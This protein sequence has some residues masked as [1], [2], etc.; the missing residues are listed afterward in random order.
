MQNIPCGLTPAELPA[1]EQS[2]Q[3]NSDFAPAINI[4]SGRQRRISK[5]FFHLPDFRLNSRGRR[6]TESTS[7]ARADTA[8]LVKFRECAERLRQPIIESSRPRKHRGGAA[9]RFRQELSSLRLTRPRWLCLLLS[10]LVALRQAHVGLPENARL[11]RGL[12][13]RAIRKL[14]IANR[15]E[16]ALRII[17][18]A[19]ILGL[20]TV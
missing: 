5:Y 8:S 13:M 15:G 10:L 16:V 20:R 14:L 9:Y 6:P 12:R 4:F 3:Q 1:R 2:H 18:S 7:I 17:R 19:Q 11:T